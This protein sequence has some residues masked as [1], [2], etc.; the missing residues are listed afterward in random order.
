MASFSSSRN[1]DSLKSHPLWLSDYGN[2]GLQRN[3]EFPPLPP[4]P[5]WESHARRKRPQLERELVSLEREFTQSNNLSKHLPEEI[6]AYTGLSPRWMGAQLDWDY[7]EV[8]LPGSWG[9]GRALLD[10]FVSLPSVAT[11]NKSL[12]SA[13]HY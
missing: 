12:I 11:L 1:T 2:N 8:P 7:L 13:F 5:P 3:R 6:K 10:L 9:V 4:W